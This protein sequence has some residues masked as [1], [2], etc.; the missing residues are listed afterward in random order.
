MNIEEII[1]VRFRSKVRNNHFFYSVGERSRIKIVVVA[2]L[3]K[4]PLLIDDLNDPC[5]HEIGVLLKFIYYILIQKEMRHIKR[6]ELY[7]DDKGLQV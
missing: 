7:G 5:D 1:T 3:K 2:V 6:R 4:S